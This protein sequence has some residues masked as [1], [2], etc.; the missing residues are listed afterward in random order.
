MTVLTGWEFI[1]M[2]KAFEGGQAGVVLMRGLTA[3]RC[4][5]LAVDIKIR[6]DLRI[7]DNPGIGVNE[8]ASEMRIS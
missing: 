3:I 6:I 7:W 8:T 1:N 4:D 2:W 5:M